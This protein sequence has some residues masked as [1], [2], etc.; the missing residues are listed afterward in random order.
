MK[1]T[2]SKAILSNYVWVVISILIISLGLRWFLAYKGGQYYFSDEHR[3]DNSRD[4]AELLIQGHFKEALSQLIISPEH[5]GFKVIGVIPAGIEHL[6]GPSLVMPAMFFSLFSV[7]NL[8]LI[9]QLSRRLGGSIE[10]ALFALFL[11][12]SSMS[13]LYY[14]RHLMPYD[15]GMFFGLLALY[16]ALEEKPSIKSSL[17]C[18]GL[19]FLCFITYNG[20]WSLAG[21]A[22]LVHVF[23]NW[24]SARR[25]ILKVL[26]VAAG[27]IVPLLFLFFIAMSFEKNMISEYGKFAT[28]INQGSFDEGWKLP[29]EYFWYAEHALIVI[30]GLLSLYAIII[31]YKDGRKCP[32]LWILGV[33]FIY[34]CLLIPSVFLHSFVVYG[35]LARQMMPFL[36]LLAAG[37]LMRLQQNIPSG[38]KIV[39]FIM[40]VI[41]IQAGWN[42]SSISNL[43]YPRDF[44]LDAQAYFPA[45][46]FS[47]KRL[48][49]GA[50]LVCQNNG[51]LIEN[52]KLFLTAPEDVP[53]ITGDLL[54]SASHPENF[55]PYGYE[56]DTL[57]QRQKFQNLNL[58][59]RFYKINDALLSNAKIKNCFVNER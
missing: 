46:E 20:Y 12:A 53:V 48:E 5:L 57:D 18:G 50:P 27:F 37:G 35:R 25:F 34:L 15:P 21:F 40:V 22:M 38:E 52:A 9:F 3:Y 13:L 1:T 47:F 19:G 30:L 6:M 32:G 58:E 26:L 41:F 23:W 45:F 49:F 7:L 39:R 4:I 33:L 59:M 43:S 17:A 55:I 10:E 36:I 2:Y 8:Y 24:E 14:A 56:G 16:V 54:L 51:Y 28:T 31:A 42:Y 44:V 29:F 11:S